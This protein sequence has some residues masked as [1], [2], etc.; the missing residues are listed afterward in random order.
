M[1]TRR[2]TSAD[3]AASLAS[4]D[5]RELLALTGLRAFAAWA[6]VAF[7]FARTLPRSELARATLATG[8]LAVDL[9]FVLSGYVLAHRY[10]DADLT[11]AAARP[12]FWSLRFARVVPLY[13]LSLCVGFAAEW[14]RSL[15][16]LGTGLGVARLIAQIALLN[17][18]WHVAMFRLNW[19]AWSL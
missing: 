14:P 5:P 11:S 7:H 9:F 15:H 16:S 1:P 8:H 6:V 12:K 10:R 4:S 13:W 3:R 19:A 2:S 18:F 17:A